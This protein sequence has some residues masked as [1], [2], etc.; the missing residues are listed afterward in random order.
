M[1]ITWY[2]NNPTVRP[3]VKIKPMTKLEKF[4]IA[5]SLSL[6]ALGVVTYIILQFIFPPQFIG[7]F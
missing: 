3:K 2:Y 1:E 4:F 7:G 6:I 5:I